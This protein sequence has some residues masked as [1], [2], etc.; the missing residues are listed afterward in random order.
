[1]C[2]VYKVLLPLCSFEVHLLW[3]PKANARLAQ[4]D[5]SK[6]EDHDYIDEQQLRRWSKRG[7]K[8]H[9]SSHLAISQ[10][11]AKAEKDDRR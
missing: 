11:L 1:M 7:G 9:R 4:K 3:L 5:C 2:R 6:G 10:D 8:M